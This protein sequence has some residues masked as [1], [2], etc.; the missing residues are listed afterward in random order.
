[1]STLPTNAW[2]SQPVPS[3]VNPASQASPILVRTVR[4]Q[5]L[6]TLTDILASS[7]H[8]Q[9][10][11]GWLYSLL[12]AGIYEDL[13]MR[14][15][16]R[17][18]HYVCL[19]AVQQRDDSEMAQAAQVQ[20]SLHLAL[21]AV[22]SMAISGDRPVGTVE[23]A[24]KMPPPWQSP[25]RRYLYISNLAVH[26]DYRRQGVARQLLQT[27]ERVAIDWGF[28]DLYLHVMENNSQARR[29]YMRAG[30][31]LMRVESSI[32]SVLLG[33]PQQLFMHK[34]LSRD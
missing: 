16:T 2:S 15:Q 22:Q 20:R 17:N 11:V 12:R 7:F 34:S 13:R 10:Q 1:M 32:T 19:V 28:Q 24:V 27:C 30:Y 8:R 14:I 18:Q 6:G 25:H 29:L 23:I 26:A 5:D 3:V 21:P 33:R 4:K 31:R 9:E